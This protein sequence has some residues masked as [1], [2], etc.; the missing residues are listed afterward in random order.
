M[1]R[2]RAGVLM[3][4]ALT[5]LLVAP[6]ANAA[7]GDVRLTASLAGKDLADYQRRPLV[8]DPAEE[9]RV[10]VEMH[11]TGT[12]RRAVRYVR[13]DGQVLG[14]TFFNY[15][16]R[17]DVDLQEDAR[18]RR[19]SIDVSDLGAQAVGLLPGRL[20]LLD[21]QRR[22]L[23]ASAVPVDVRGSLGSAYGVFGLLVAACTGLLLAAALTRLAL[24][25]LTENRWFR[26]T[27][28]AVP[29]IGVGLTLTFS[30]SAFGVLVPEPS[31]SLALA[32]GGGVVGLILGF[33]TPTPERAARS[34]PEIPVPA[35]APALRHEP[36]A[37]LPDGAPT[38][39]HGRPEP[40]VAPP[41]RRPP[42]P[43]VPAPAPGVDAGRA[44]PLAA[45][46]HTG[47]PPAGRC[48]TCPFPQCRRASAPGTTAG[49]HPCPLGTWSRSSPPRWRSSW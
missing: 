37:G 22:V 41:Q 8:L 11:N 6:S 25:R 48:G 10:Q 46:P 1:S 24:G 45:S 15:S 2:L 34:R 43:E 19:F 17:V 30:L 12:T 47:P 29:G 26:A 40:D 32:V 4:V 31:S 38:P 5:G 23:A 18:A 20:V 16:V 42:T 3:A 7:G 36:D 33:L 27:R 14:T 21:E 28:F 44:E 9:L 13:L 49:E 39:L 35:G